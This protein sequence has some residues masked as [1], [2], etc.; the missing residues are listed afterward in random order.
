[1]KISIFKRNFNVQSRRFHLI[2]S[3][4]VMQFSFP[5]DRML[6]YV[7]FSVL[8]CCSYFFFLVSVLKKQ[9]FGYTFFFGYL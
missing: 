1:L 4:L 6:L 7:S 8:I 9:D 3:L 2:N 5:A